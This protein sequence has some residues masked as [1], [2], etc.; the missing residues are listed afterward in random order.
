MTPILHRAKVQRWCFSHRAVTRAHSE[1]P[2]IDSCAVLLDES[3]RVHDKFT[4]QR[5][6][7]PLS[8]RRWR[9]TGR[10]IGSDMSSSSTRELWVV[11]SSTRTTRTKRNAI[12]LGTCERPT[13]TRVPTAIG[14]GAMEH[15][16]SHSQINSIELSLRSERA[17]SREIDL[18]PAVSLL[19]LTVSIRPIRKSPNQVETGQSV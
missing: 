12:R 4:G 16:S 11:E 8:T 7:S 19:H 10:R 3:N 13:K 14:G 5:S 1:C 6:L 15:L 9:C 2:Q 18:C 17:N